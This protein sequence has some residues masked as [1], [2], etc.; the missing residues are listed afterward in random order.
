[1]ADMRKD[2]TYALLF[3]K[4]FQVPPPPG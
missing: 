4:W 3:Q 2:G 1:L